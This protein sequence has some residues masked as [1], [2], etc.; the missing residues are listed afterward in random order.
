MF[1]RFNDFKDELVCAYSIAFNS[2]TTKLYCGYNKCI[3][4]FDINRPGKNYEN[5]FTASKD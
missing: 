5:I 4:V 2:T 3:K 1:L